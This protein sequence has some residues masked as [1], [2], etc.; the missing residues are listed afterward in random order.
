MNLAV[1]FNEMRLLIILILLAADTSF[2]SLDYN[3]AF[4]FYRQAVYQL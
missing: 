1:D 2:Y 3:R 4:Y